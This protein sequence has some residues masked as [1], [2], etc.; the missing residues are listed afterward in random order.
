MYCRFLHLHKP[1]FLKFAGVLQFAKM[2]VPNYNAAAYPPSPQNARRDTHEIKWA[3]TSNIPNSWIWRNLQYVGEN[4]EDWYVFHICC[5]SCETKWDSFPN[6][7][8]RRLI[9]STLIAHKHF[10]PTLDTD[11]VWSYFRGLAPIFPTSEMCGG[12]GQGVG[13]MGHVWQNWD[14][15][16]FKVNVKCQ[17]KCYFRLHVL[18][19]RN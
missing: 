13:G 5:N 2:K 18:G 3:Q 9:V 12:S 11:W 6:V 7:A 10:V 16:L 8:L 19:K 17:S 14:K 15:P 1:F 4:G